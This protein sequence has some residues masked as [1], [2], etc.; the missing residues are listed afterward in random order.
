VTHEFNCYC[1]V[2]EGLH[3]ESLRLA[4]DLVEQVLAVDPYTVLKGRL[5]SAHQLRDFQRAEAL[6][7]MPVLGGRKP[8]QLMVA[9]L[10][11][12]RSASSSPVSSCAGCPGS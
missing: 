1:L 5:L 8:S 2:V 12:Q 3:H 7:D 10:E 4:A 6:F 9:M 11:G